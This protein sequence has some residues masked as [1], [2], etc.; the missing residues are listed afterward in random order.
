MCDIIC[1][2]KAVFFDFDGTLTYKSHNIWKMIWVRCGYRTDANSY[3][4]QLFRDFMANKITHQ[5]WCDLT[6]SEFNKAKFDKDSLVELAKDIKLID[7]V[8]ETLKI[9]KDNGFYLF[10]V[11]GNIVSVIDAVLGDKK[12]YFDGI[13]ANELFFDEAGVINRIKGTNYDFEGKAKFISEFKEKYDASAKNLYFVGNGSNDEWAHLSGCNTICIN[14]EE[15]DFENNTKW[16]K[17]VNNIDNLTDILTFI[18]P[19]SAEDKQDCKTKV[20]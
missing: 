5:E 7:G 19:K 13:M 1:Y 15:T 20:E 3:Y 16:H 6:F 14:P 2:M 8:E 18:L 17:C 4:A 9:L 12:Q 10:V 11:S